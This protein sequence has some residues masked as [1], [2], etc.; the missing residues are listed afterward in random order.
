MVSIN[1]LFFALYV[2]RDLIINEFSVLAE[3]RKM[4]KR[5][6]SNQKGFT[7]IE[8]VMVIVVIGILAAVAIPKFVDLKSSAHNAVI[9]GA[10]GA[11]QGAIVMLHSQYIVSGTSY[12]ATSV[13]NQVSQ[14]GLTLAAGSA[15]SIV[16]TLANATTTVSWTYT[17]V[18]GNATMAQITAPAAV[19]W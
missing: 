18:S 10:T 9:N 1:G 4:G 5:L 14:Q 16:G 13:A 17:A 12:D 19:T 2:R 15:T 3:V 7:I 8:L 11:L 6:M